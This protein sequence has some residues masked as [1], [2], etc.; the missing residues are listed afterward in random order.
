MKPE[1]NSETNPDQ[2]IADSLESLR[3]CRLLLLDPS[4][5]SIDYCR[6]V[7]AQCTERIEGLIRDPNL[8]LSTNGAFTS[9]LRLIRRELG[10]IAGLLESAAAF[11]RDMLRVTC[12]ATPAPV[13]PIDAPGIKARRVHVL[14]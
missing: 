7:M 12:G 1:M 2:L 5:Q 8:V 14:G 6:I 9:S 4:P 13:V 3:Q 10:A 11:R